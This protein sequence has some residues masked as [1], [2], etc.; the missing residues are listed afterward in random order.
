[1]N[2]DDDILQGAAEDANVVSYI[3]DHLPAELNDKFSD[4]QL[5]YI[6]DVIAEYY[7][8]KGIF[9]ND[10]DGYVD[11]NIDEVAEYVAQKAQKENFCTFSSDDLVAVVEAELDFEEQLEE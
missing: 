7:A 3:Q 9:D 8:E 10:E 4:E 5:Y 11:V 2:T 1:M 6:I